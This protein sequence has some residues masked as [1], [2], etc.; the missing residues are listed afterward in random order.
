MLSPEVLHWIR[1]DDALCPGTEAFQKLGVGFQNKRTASSRSENNRKHISAGKLGDCKR[2][3]C[4]GMDIKSDLPVP[5]ICAW[6]LAFDEVNAP[7]MEKADAEAKALMRHSG[8]Q[9]NNGTNFLESRWPAYWCTCA[10]LTFSDARGGWLEEKHTDG[11]QSVLH[12]GLTFYGRRYL[13]LYDA[14]GG[15]HSLL[16]EP[17][18][19]YMGTLTGPQHQARHAD[20][21]AHELLQ[22]PGLGNLSSAVMMR[23]SLFPRD[24][25]WWLKRNAPVTS[26]FSCLSASFARSIAQ[27]QFRLPTLADCEQAF[28]R[29]YPLRNHPTSE[30]PQKK[31]CPEHVRRKIASKRPAEKGPDDIE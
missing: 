28:G 17:G 21:E 10:E 14:E 22:V 6:K 18:T 4:M 1:A 12:M 7:L 11:L 24:W 3:S 20:A 27:S 30:S 13:D 23:S 5:S 15:V 2:T 31:Q 25:C 8:L 26:S 19:V 16:N 29:L 9:D